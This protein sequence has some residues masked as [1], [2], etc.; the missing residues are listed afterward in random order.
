MMISRVPSP[1]YINY[2]LSHNEIP[3]RPRVSINRP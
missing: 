2:L 3:V 1:M